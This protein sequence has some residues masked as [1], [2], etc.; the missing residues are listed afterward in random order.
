MLRES[1]EVKSNAAIITVLDEH[2]AE[3]QTLVDAAL[4]ISL[5]QDVDSRRSSRFLQD[6]DVER[7]TPGV[8]VICG[9][10]DKF[11]RSI[12]LRIVHGDGTAKY[13][14]RAA[15]CKR[16]ATH[17][18]TQPMVSA[19]LCHTSSLNGVWKKVVSG[20]F[21]CRPATRSDFAV[22][23][24]GSLAVLKGTPAVIVNWDDE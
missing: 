19:K 8:V 13:H 12:A 22:V 4:L 14:V 23:I 2:A 7:T 17:L 1:S 5:M 11:Q 6:A 24:L 16:Q 9:T 3:D 18:S 10:G 21:D 20:V 15:G